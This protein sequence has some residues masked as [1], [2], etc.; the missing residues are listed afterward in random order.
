[1][2]DTIVND[3]VPTT[4]PSC[5]TAT[6]PADGATN[7]NVRTTFTWPDAAGAS[8]YKL[9][10]GTTS[11]GTDIL[12]GVTASSGATLTN[13][14]PL[15]ANTKYYLKIVPTNDV[16]DATGCTETSFT[17]GSNP[18][19]PY[20]GPFTSTTP[21]QMA[22]ITSFTLNGVTNTSDTSAT[23]FGSYSPNESFTGSP[24]EVKDV[25]GAY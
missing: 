3:T 4:V 6:A 15:N 18:Y 11:G 23:T 10:L 12:N 20:C 5:T 22:P 2:F 9:Y 21:T 19:A 16:G 14:P 1:M 25:I 8:G 13:N 24:V 7:V 17:T